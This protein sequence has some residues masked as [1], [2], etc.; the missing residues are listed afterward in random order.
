MQEQL[1]A[2]QASAARQAEKATIE[3]LM[4]AVGRYIRARQANDYQAE[5]AAIREI[6]R[7]Q[8]FLM[9]RGFV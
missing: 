8:I 7:L 5:V 2:I 9:Q 4:H 6:Q 1:L 3:A